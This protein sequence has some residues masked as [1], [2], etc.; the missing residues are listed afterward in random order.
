M[1]TVT[2][3]IDIYKKKETKNRLFAIS[4]SLFSHLEKSGIISEFE[5][6]TGSFIDEYGTCQ[7]S[8]QHAGSLFMLIKNKIEEKKIAKT[9]EVEQFIEFLA[10][11]NKTEMDLDFIGD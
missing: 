6:M 5:K 1:Q 9:K 10:F 7:L 8:Y 3:G 4:D 2:M 11:S